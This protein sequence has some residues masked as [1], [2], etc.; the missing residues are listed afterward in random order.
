MSR[1]FFSRKEDVQHPIDYK[2]IVICRHEQ[3]LFFRKIFYIQLI[4]KLLWDIN[5]K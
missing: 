2:T 1:T 3:N 5:K 4:M